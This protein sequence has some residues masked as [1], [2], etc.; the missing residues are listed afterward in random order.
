MEQEGELMSSSKERRRVKCIVV[1]DVA[2]LLIDRN[3]YKVAAKRS[4]EPNCLHSLR[5]RH[6]QNLQIW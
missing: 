5:A 3:M 2:E 1:S 4:I 6:L